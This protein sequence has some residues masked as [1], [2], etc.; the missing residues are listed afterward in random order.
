MGKEKVLQ[1]TRSIIFVPCQSIH[2]HGHNMYVLH[3]RDGLWDGVSTVRPQ[4]P[5]RRDTQMLRV[6]GHMV[7]QYD[8]DNPGTWPIH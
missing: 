6:N 3:E 7:I 8:T 1:L 4:N 5:Q 2:L